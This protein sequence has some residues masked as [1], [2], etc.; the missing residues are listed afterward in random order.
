MRLSRHAIAA[1]VLLGGLVVADL[2]ADA[3]TQAIQP[4]RVLDTRSGIGGTTGRLAVGQ[5]LTLA[6]PA[7]TQPVRH[8]WC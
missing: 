1:S 7:A 3:A 6:V 5:K 8:R 4:V 2:P